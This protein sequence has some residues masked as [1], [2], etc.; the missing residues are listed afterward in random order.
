MPAVGGTSNK[1]YSISKGQKES[2]DLLS[3]VIHVSTPRTPS[4][5][6]PSDG[7]KETDSRYCLAAA[8][9]QLLSC[10]CGI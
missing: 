5:P 8:T 4:S 9:S 3:S 6:A 2:G 7:T 1:V 10:S